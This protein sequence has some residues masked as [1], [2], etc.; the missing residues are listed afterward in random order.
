[1]CLAL[2]KTAA[3][4]NAKIR[5]SDRKRPRLMEPHSDY[6]RLAL[7]TVANLVRDGCA[8]HSWA[9]PPACRPSTISWPRSRTSLPSRSRRLRKDVIVDGYR[10]KHLEWVVPDPPEGEG[11]SWPSSGCMGGQLKSWV[12]FIYTAEPGDAFYGYTGPG[13]REEFWVLDVEGTRLMIAAESSPRNA[14]A[15]P[16][17]AAG[18]GRVPPNGALRRGPGPPGGCASGDQGMPR[19]FRRPLQF[20]LSL[21]RWG[22]PLLHPTNAASSA[23]AAWRSC[24]AVTWL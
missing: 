14:R 16:R 11:D 6:M 4:P 20:L 17:R 21:G 3:D 1:M 22:G 9:D 18:D 7:T 10:G 12:G 13:Y 19:Q 15:G 5:I 8:D 23:S 24:A 2:G